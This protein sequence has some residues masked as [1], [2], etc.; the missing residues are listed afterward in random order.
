MVCA[1]LDILL[2]VQYFTGES[3]GALTYTLIHAVEHEPNLT[4]GRLL[5]VMS[6]KI[7]EAQRQ[8]GQPPQVCKSNLA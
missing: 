3:A 6:K 5:N 4:Y 7:S 2:N 1:N 8:L